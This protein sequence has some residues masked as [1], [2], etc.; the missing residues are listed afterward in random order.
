[1][2]GNNTF[3]LGSAL[4]NGSIT[5]SNSSRYVVTWNGSMASPVKMF[6]NTL[7]TYRFDVGDNSNYTPFTLTLTNGA[8]TG[9]F[10][11][12]ST[13][14]QV[15]PLLGTSSN[16][17]KRYW[18][19][20]QTGLSEGFTYNVSFTYAD[21]DVVGSESVL[22]PYKWTPGSGLGTGWI[23]C[24]GS[25]A[26]FT[27]GSGSV[28]LAG[29]TMQWQGLYSFSDFTGNGGG[30]PLPITLLEF[31]ATAGSRGVWLQWATLSE[32]NNE[33]FVVEKSRDGQ[34]FEEVS[35]VKGAGNHNGR[36]NYSSFDDKTYTGVSY[37]RLAQRDFSG[38]T[39]YSRLVAV[40]YKGETS[41]PLR[42][43]PNPVTNGK[44]RIEGDG[45]QSIQVAVMD[46][47]GR[48][49]MQRVLPPAGETIDLL[50][51]SSGAYFV[52]MSEGGNSCVKK[53]LVK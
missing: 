5:G 11:T 44:L 15:H 22:F 16:Y 48:E 53:L 26:A 46:A 38:E 52:K 20:N 43:Y 39:H 21:A 3:S 6:A 35:R 25:G 29:N 24:G 37:Y 23:G 2:G 34:E 49:L 31:D 32:L 45:K 17:L 9:S 14:P 18:S 36:L 40:E 47:Q 27:M 1:M 4:S 30:T 51:L 7:G 50:G 12:C 10:L 13:T 41:E 19:L 8:N 28:N 42:M 33:G